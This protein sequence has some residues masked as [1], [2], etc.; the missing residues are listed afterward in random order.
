[1]AVTLRVPAEFACCHAEVAGDF[2]AWAPVVMCREPAGDYSLTVRLPRG[3]LWQYR[4]LVD[5]DRWINDPRA[6]DYVSRADGGA[7]SVLQ[8]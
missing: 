3:R 5:G 6:D 2:T 7:A 4:F 8:T 1:M